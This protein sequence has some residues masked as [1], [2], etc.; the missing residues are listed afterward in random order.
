MATAERIRETVAK[1]IYK[2]HARG[3]PGGKCKSSS[4]TPTFQAMV[5]SLRDEKMIRRHFD[6]RKEAELW[7]G[8]TRGGVEQGKVRA[9]SKITVREAGDALLAGMR[10][11]TL[12][13]RSGRRYKP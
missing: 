5:Y 11:G 2:I 6:T 10:D 8:E 9:P 13:S 7:R 1:G 12:K 3:C 4:C